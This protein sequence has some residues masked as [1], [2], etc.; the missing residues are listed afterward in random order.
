MYSVA[1][2]VDG[3]ILV[4]GWFTT[5]GGVR[6]SFIGRLN[7]DGTLDNSFNPGASAAVYSLAL[8]ADGKVLVGGEF[9]SLGEQSRNHLGRLNADGTADTSFNPGAGS[10]V[11]SLAVQADGKILVGGFF[12]TLG[13]QTRIGI[14]RVN[15]DGTLDASFNPGETTPVFSLALQADG[16]ILVG[17]IFSRL[18]GQY[19]NYIG[20]LNNTAPATQ[21]LTL[22]SSALT[23]VRG[24]TSPEV[25]RTTFEYSPDGNSWTILDG[26]SR[27]P[28]GW[29]L[30][31]LALP[32]NTTFRARGYTVGGDGNASGWFVEATIGAPAI[33]TQPASLTNN[34]SDSVT[35]SVTAVGTLPLS[36]QWWK[37]GA[38][39]I[40]A[41]Q[42]SLSF[43]DLQ[44]WDDGSYYVVVSNAWGSVTSTVAVVSVIVGPDSFN[45]GA[46]G[47]VYSLAQQVDGK[48]L[49]GGTFTTLGGQT[50][51]YIGRLNA[52]GT[53]DTSFNPGAN[54]PVYS[55][56]QQ[57]DGKILVGG[58]FTT[59]GGRTAPTLVG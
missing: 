58:N 52:D 34:A 1:L 43:G 13:G 40:G 57:A 25:W 44:K 41:T 10:T 32:T 18:G 54:N 22:D 7:G 55:L 15:A 46:S 56:A 23:W 12:W 26:G 36:Y 6:R 47:T 16:K 21:S 8:Q 19:R 50:R 51:N 33:T 42:A 5:L 28:G 45:P 11:Q 59:L 9:N 27:V 53:L 2:Q 29:Q 4:G 3:K 37:D 30:T 38:A 20:R 49:V 24:G 48:V 31:G 39:L 35:L 14:G 17:G